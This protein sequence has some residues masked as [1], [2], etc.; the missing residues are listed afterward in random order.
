MTYLNNL[1]KIPIDTDF[2][3]NYYDKILFT[4]PQK[5]KLICLFITHLLLIL[6]LY[7]TPFIYNNIYFNIFYLT[8]TV[9]MICGWI[10]FNGECWINSLEKKILDPDYKNGDNLDVNPG[11]DYILRQIYELVQPINKLFI[12]NEKQ[13]INDG[14]YMKKKQ[15]RYKTPLII[16]LVSFTWFLWLRFKIIPVK[17]RV[18]LNITFFCILMVANY[19]WAR[20]DSLYIWN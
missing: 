20:I 4:H 1:E 11:F 16:P 14:S 8:L 3:N 18:F 5:W 10:V 13:I 2:I 9:A 15:F 6:A 17:Y 19:N 7:M 12:K